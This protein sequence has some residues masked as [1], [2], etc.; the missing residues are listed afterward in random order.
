MAEGSALSGALAA[1]ALGRL[2]GLRV[3]GVWPPEP[4]PCLHE[5]QVGPARVFLLGLPSDP[6]P[7]LALL[8]PDASPDRQRRADRFRFPLDALHCLAGEALLRHALAK[9]PGW[10]GAALSFTFGPEGKPSLLG[11]PGLHFNLSHSGPWV[12]CALHHEPVGIDVEASRVWNPLPAASAMTPEELQHLATLAPAEASAF[13]YRI[14][15]LKESLLKAI[16]TGL[17]LDPRGI[18]LHF[19]GTAITATHGERPMGH[20]RLRTLPMPEGAS[21]A[22]CY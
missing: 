21:A 13:F 11:H 19:K 5:F 4:G 8:H 1:S 9:R 20:L 12:L 22:I 7:W 6:E 2:P 3:A 16:G 15:T 17:S 14:W 10:D 18:R